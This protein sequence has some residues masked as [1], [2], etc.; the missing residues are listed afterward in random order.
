MNKLV[1]SCMDR[2]LN[3]FIEQHY[4]DC[5][6]IRNAGANVYPI[7]KEIKDLIKDKDIRE[8]VLLAHTDCGAMKKVFGVIKDRKPVDLDLEDNLISH[9]RDLNFTNISELE[10]DNL[11]LQINKLKDEFPETKIE[12][13]LLQIEDI[14]VPEEE[15]IHELIIANPSKPGYSG[16]LNELSLNHF[17]VYVLQSDINNVMPD[18]KLAVKD[19]GVKFIHLISIE[20]EN[21][22]DRKVDQE[23][24]N[25]IFNKEGIKIST[26]SYPLKT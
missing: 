23:K 18:L 22:R 5:F 24:L 4:S 21:P 17:S 8:I 10:K 11:K 1:I 25:L 13:R 2:R 9:Y 12:G 20:K 14:K 7:T 16:L 19:L 26:Y 3:D 15:G 6:V